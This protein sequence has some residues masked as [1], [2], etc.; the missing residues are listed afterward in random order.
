MRS[1]QTKETSLVK[2]RIAFSIVFLSLLPLLA[3][4]GVPSVPTDILRADFSDKLLG[5]PIGTGGA[6]VGEPISLFPLQTEVVDCP[7]S[8]CLQVDNDLSAPSARYIRWQFLGNSE[9]TSGVVSLRFTFTPSARDRYGFAVR[10]RNSSTRTFLTIR[11][12]SAGTLEA[13]DS[14]GIIPVNSFTYSANQ[15]LDFQF[16]F[17]LDA[18]TSQATIN[19]TVLF[20]ERMHGITDRGV[21][22]LLTGFAASSSGNSFF[23]D[24]VIAQ[25]EEALP[26]ILTADFENETLNQAL[27]PGNAENN[28]PT[29]ID[30]AISTQ[31]VLADADNQALTMSLTSPSGLAAFARWNFLD[32]IEVLEGVVAIEMDVQFESL[33]QYQFTVREAGSST[34]DYTSVYFGGDSLIRVFN[35]GSFIVAPINYSAGVPYRLRLTFDQTEGTY[36]LFLDDTALVIDRPHGLS[37]GRGIGVLN[38][39]F[40]STATAGASMLI[41]DLQVG[42]SDV[43]GI[44]SELVILQQPASGALGEALAPTL[45]I[46]VLNVFDQLVSGATVTID[47][48]TGP[49]GAALSHNV[50]DSF[51]GMASFPDLRASTV[52][53]Y[54][55]R[56]KADRAQVISTM[57]LNVAA[58]T[59]FIFYNDFESP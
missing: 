10:E 31:V 4:A 56:A 25:T 9:I 43:A 55:L 26:L 57:D 44:A 16:D 48:F 27:P 33:N 6:S 7:D 19:D 24:D 53:I 46:G 50:A 45:E 14:Q 47:V 40:Q 30:P 21:G 23:I 29:A 28:R 15:R 51:A 32:G 38:M 22:A 41:D 58:S 8:R 37:N 49:M 2:T 11:L 36:S 59:V 54:R 17:D 52:G 1:D 35:G 13:T 20:T 42:A 34:A 18:G 3:M 39:G 12:D 5:Q